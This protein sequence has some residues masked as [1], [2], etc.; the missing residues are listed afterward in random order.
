MA[1]Y[2][3]DREWMAPALYLKAEIYL[4]T[5]S[6]AQAEQVVQELK[7]SYPDSEWMRK[8]MALL[9]STKKEG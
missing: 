2:P 9:Q 1:L 4:N 6:M 8:A 3:R 7:W 5:G